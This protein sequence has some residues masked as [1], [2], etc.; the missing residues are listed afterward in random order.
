MT[1]PWTQSSD[2]TVSGVRPLWGFL[3]AAH[4]GCFLHWAE[5]GERKGKWHSQTSCGDFRPQLSPQSTG[6]Y[7]HVLEHFLSIWEGSM[8]SWWG[9][10]TDHTW[11]RT[12]GLEYLF[13][14]GKDRSLEMVSLLPANSIWNFESCLLQSLLSASLSWCLAF[15]NRLSC[16]G[17]SFL[18]RTSLLNLTVDLMPRGYRPRMSSASLDTGRVVWSIENRDQELDRPRFKSWPHHLY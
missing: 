1:V 8:N 7:S 6:I 16:V 2:S 10:L 3:P 15:A 12:A 13:L 11:L 5:G 14:F 4:H 18:T 17:Q 9:T